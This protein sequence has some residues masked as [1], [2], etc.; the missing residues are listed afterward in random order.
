VGQRNVDDLRPSIFE[1]QEAMRL[2]WSL[3]ILSSAL[4]G[5]Y[6]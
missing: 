3:I 5:K 4:Q 2:Q 6:A 1:N